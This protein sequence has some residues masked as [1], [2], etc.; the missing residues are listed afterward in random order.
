MASDGSTGLVCEADSNVCL[1]DPLRAN[2]DFERVCPDIRFKRDVVSRTNRYT[3][4][5]MVGSG[6][7]KSII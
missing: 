5:N 1:N 4:W 3:Q 7:S 6:S 2:H